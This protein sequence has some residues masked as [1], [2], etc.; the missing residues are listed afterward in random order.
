M[1]FAISTD[2]ERL[3]PEDTIE[4]NLEHVVNQFRVA[5]AGGFEMG[6]VGEHHGHEYTI[7]PN[8]FSLLT[9]I[10]DRTSTIRL[11]P[12]VVCAPYW[13]PVKLAGEATLFD[14]MSGGRLELGIG[15]GAF[16]YEFSRMADGI[17]PDAARDALAEMM[18]ALR[19]LWA[20]NY[21]HDGKNWRFAKTTSCPR[22]ITAEGPPLWVA[23]RNPDSFRIAV[24]NRANVMVNQLGLGMEELVS[25]NERRLEA[26]DEFGDG[27][28]PEMMALRSTHVAESEEE[29]L[30]AAETYIEHR[31]YF[32]NL[33]DTNG[34]V[35]DGWVGFRDPRQ[36]G[37]AAWSDPAVIRYNQMYDTAENMIHRL[38]EY[39]AAGVEHYLYLVPPRLTPEQQI[40]S[41]RRFATD[42]MPAFTEKN[43]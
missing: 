20:G 17:E 42:V 9:Y 28:V 23:A 43:K 40:E 7:G 36:Y 14:H 11:G 38:R 21:A 13:H 27:F 15:R 19:G 8:P 33:F 29:I 1:R 3:S 41:I 32:D 26:A 37:E 39:E 18:P 5:E 4:A 10:A 2:L 22:P 35:V 34:E 12:A 30:M 31:G 16:P 6:F 25:L 24:E